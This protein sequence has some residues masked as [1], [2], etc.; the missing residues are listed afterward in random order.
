MPT[1]TLVAIAGGLLSAVL[2]LAP[3]AG[4]IFIGFHYATHIPLFL[5]GLAMGTGPV[6][7]AS[8]TASVLTLL[9]NVLVGGIFMIAY[10]VPVILLARQALLNRID[11]DGQTEWYPPGHLLALATAYAVALLVAANFAFVGQEGGLQGAIEGLLDEVLASLESG[12]ALPPKDVILRYAFLFPG[13]AGAMWVLI[14]AVNGVMAQALAVRLKRNLRPTPHYSRL[15]LPLW[16]T[17]TLSA[18]ALLWLVGGESALG[19]LSGAVLVTVLMPFFLL[20]LAVIHSVTRAMRIPTLI[21]GVFYVFLVLQLWPALVVAG[22]GIIE[23]WAGIRDRLK[24]T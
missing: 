16:L 11:A 8:A 20:G 14:V 10:A 6:V 13:L 23:P 21:L 22:L 7:V 4:A 5:V 2:Y 17:F 15:K 1:P 9:F 18:I 24:T 19:F 3:L 12:M